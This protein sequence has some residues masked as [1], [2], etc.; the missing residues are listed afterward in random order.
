VS[1]V[2]APK[3]RLTPSADLNTLIQNLVRI[4]SVN[5][6]LDPAH[7]GETEIARFVADWAVAHGLKVDWLESTPGRPSV[8]VTAPGSGGGRNLLLNAHLDTVGVIDMATPFEPEIRDGRMYGRGVM[9]MKAS[10]A[11]CML[12]V[13]HASSLGLSGDVILTAVADEEHGSVGTQEALAVV[14]AATRIDAAIVTEPSDLDLHVAHRGFAL[15]EVEFEGKA[16]HTSQ[17]EKGVNA[18]SHLSRLLGSVE[19]QDRA[20]QQRSPHPLL[21]HGSLQPVLAAGGHELFTTPRSAGVTLERRTLPG[22][23][24]AAAQ[25][26]LQAL[27]D[28][29]AREDPTVKAKMRAQIARE[30]FEAAADSEIVRFLCAAVAAERGDA[31]ELLGAPYWTDAALVAEAGIPTVLF[32]PVGGGIHQPSEWLDVDSAHVVLRVLERVIGSFAV[33]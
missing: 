5:P 32:G 23:T 17:P 10:L 3:N 30:P 8:V 25:A 12:A 20:L 21:A 31:P 33:P 2:I 27:L 28:E 14:T 16:S 4:D 1:L 29:L 22:E 9:D 24:A 6:A 26:E 18:L 13:A 7:P 15:F 11:A 19:R